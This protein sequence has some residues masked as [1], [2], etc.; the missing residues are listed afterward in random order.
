MAL[1]G[2]IYALGGAARRAG[3]A[4]DAAGSRL[5]GPTAYSECRTF[6][7]AGGERRWLVDLG[8]FL[9]FCLAGGL[10]YI[11]AVCE[12]L[13]PF[14][15]V[16]GG[17]GGLVWLGA[18]GDYGDVAGGGTTLGRCRSDEGGLAGVFYSP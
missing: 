1:R 18:L 5:Q 7:R 16:W 12:L 3:V 13:L 8:P 10:L 14:V 17:T 11:F 15:G 9:I 2:V 6:V 4:I